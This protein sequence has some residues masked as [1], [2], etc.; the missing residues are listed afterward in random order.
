MNPHAPLAQSVQE[1]VIGFLFRVFFGV[2]FVR[3]AFTIPSVC[4]EPYTGI[5]SRCR[6]M[7][8]ILA[9]TSASFSNRADFSCQCIKLVGKRQLDAA[10]QQELTFANHV[11]QFDAGQYIFGGPK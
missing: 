9:G 8:V 4:I 1:V 7:N 5:L 2:V 11:H 10:L 3:R 6:L